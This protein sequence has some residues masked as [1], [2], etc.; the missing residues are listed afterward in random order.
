MEVFSCENGYFSD[1][2]KFIRIEKW[3]LIKDPL[4]TKAEYIWLKVIG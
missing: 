1:L 3:N 2:E 4:L